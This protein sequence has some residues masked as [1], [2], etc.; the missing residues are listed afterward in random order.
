MFKEKKMNE[1]N[2]PTNQSSSSNTTNLDRPNPL[3]QKL[4]GDL[5]DSSE[6][7]S[8]SDIENNIETKFVLNCSNKLNLIYYLERGGM[9]WI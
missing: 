9:L 3:L 8:E 4:V 5:Y 2:E 1:Y 6:E 7:N